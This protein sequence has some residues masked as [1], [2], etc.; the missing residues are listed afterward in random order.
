MRDLY[1]FI[2]F[3]AVASIF[4]SQCILIAAEGQMSAALLYAEN[5][6]LKAALQRKRRADDLPASD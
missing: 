2:A 3:A 6:A 1:V 5:Q 4:A